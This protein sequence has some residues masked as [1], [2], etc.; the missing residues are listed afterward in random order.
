MI[1]QQSDPVPPLPGV[2]QRR[3]AH[4]ARRARRGL[5]SAHDRPFG[6][7]GGAG[8]YAWG[9]QRWCGPPPRLVPPSPCADR[10]SLRVPACALVGK[11]LR[12]GGGTE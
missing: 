9:A 8:D 7:A 12:N 4:A 1:G 11:T 10:A 3:L 6:A 2:V 5:P